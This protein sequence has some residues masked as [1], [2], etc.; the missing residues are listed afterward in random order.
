VSTETPSDFLR[1]HFFTEDEVAGIAKRTKRTLRGWRQQRVGPP[2]TRLGR[3]VI[4]YPKQGLLDFLGDQE[5]R[6]VQGRAA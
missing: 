2:W 1:E 3:D 5:V 4:L 6:P